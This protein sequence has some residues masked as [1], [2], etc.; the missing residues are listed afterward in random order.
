MTEKRQNIRVGEIDFFRFVFSVII[1]F[2]H[3]EYLLG[4]N[5]IF[6]GGAFGVEYFFIVSGYLMM[7]SIEK[8]GTTKNISFETT[9]FLK[10]KIA[11]IYPEFLLSFAIGFA[12]QC[13]L[14]ALPW[15]DIGQLFM[16]SSFELLLVQETGIGENSVNSVIWYVQSMLLCM[17]IL[18]PLIR[19]YP[20][21]MRRLGLPL[22]TLLLL[23]YIYQTYTHLR[24]PSRWLG[25]TYKGNIRAMAELCLGTECYFATQYLRRLRLKNIAKNL[26]TILKWFCWVLIY[27]Y[28]WDVELKHDMFM[29]GVICVAVVLTFSGQCVD[30]ERFQNKLVAFLGKFSL[31]LYLCHIYYARYLPAVL[32]DGMRYRYK[33][34]CYMS[35]SLLTAMM[36]MYLAGLL[37]KKLPSIRAA[38]KRCFLTE[39]S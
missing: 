31:P 21:M 27:V 32:P 39:V 3:A 15:R 13:L 35:C 29:L 24:N 9:S 20:E 28:M 34:I 30:K 17:A 19:K 36:V 25:F 26:L 10:R 33:L 14:K 18:Y 37:R 11:A 6:P 23:G 12:V 8:A 2:R 16:R 22:I 7:A 38:M 1:M 4:E 5:L